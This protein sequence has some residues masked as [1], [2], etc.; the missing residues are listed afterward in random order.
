MNMRR[1]HLPELSGFLMKFAP[2]ILRLAVLGL[3]SSGFAL[4][5]PYLSKLFI[6]QSLLT[7]NIPR[8]F[9]LGMIGEYL[10][11]IIHQ[12]AQRPQSHVRRESLPGE[13]PPA[14]GRA[15]E[16]PAPSGP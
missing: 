10:I 2:V 9:S 15:G 8:F 12:T 1:I 16:H 3:V 6:D 11:R 14:A 4:A 7:R 5:V 13:P